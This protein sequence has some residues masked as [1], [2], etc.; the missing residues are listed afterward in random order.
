MPA[1]T[2]S[3]EQACS[4]ITSANTTSALELCCNNYN[5]GDG[6]L[7]FS[8]GSCNTGFVSSSTDN[9]FYDCL[10]DLIQKSQ[11]PAVGSG[12]VCTEDDKD[13]RA[14]AGLQTS[15]SIPGVFTML[16]VGS[17]ILLL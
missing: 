1:N 6:P 12:V 7:A 11:F 10:F 3:S 4:M 9:E 15:P 16:L 5:E 13:D 14:G 8:Q 2:T 17:S